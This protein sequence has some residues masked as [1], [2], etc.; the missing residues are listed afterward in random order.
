MATKGS[1]SP[2][3]LLL[4]GAGGFY[5]YKTGKLQQIFH[6]NDLVKMNEMHLRLTG[7][8]SDSDGSV[9]ADIEMLNPTSTNFE[10][11]SIVGNFLVNGVTIGTV[12]MFGDTVVHGNS[13]STLPVNV[14]VNPKAIVLF[15]KKGSRIQF[16]GNIN[17]NNHLQ[18]LTMNYDI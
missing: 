10:I 8:H 11:Q 12:K 17:I 9:N 2:L 5:L 4:A 7:F 18:P 13:Q 6:T 3:L 14:R 1:I 15:R 16:N